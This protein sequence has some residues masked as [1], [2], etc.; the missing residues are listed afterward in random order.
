MVGLSHKEYRGRGI[1]VLDYYVSDDDMGVKDFVLGRKVDLFDSMET[2][3]KRG[4][5]DISDIIKIVS[6]EVSILSR[7]R[8]FIK[9]HNE[10][11]GIGFISLTAIRKTIGAKFNR[12]DV[13]E[14]IIATAVAAKF[15]NPT[16]Q[17]ELADVYTIVDKLT[18]TNTLELSNDVGNLIKL[19]VKLKKNS[20]AAFTNISIRKKLTLEYNAAIKYANSKAVTTY[21]KLIRDS[22]KIDTAIISSDGVS[23]EKGTKVDMSVW[24]GHGTQRDLR[25]LSHLSLSLKSGNTVTMSQ[26]G[27][28]PKKVVEFWNFFD[29]PVDVHQHEKSI[30]WFTNMFSEITG[31]IESRLGN[32]INEKNFIGALAKGIKL[33][34][35]N[36]DDS[37][38]V[39]HINKGNFNR[40]SFK[41]LEDKLHTI[42]IGVVLKTDNKLPRMAIIDK[43]SDK[44]LLGFRLE[45]RD[46]GVTY[47]LH[48]E[49]G[50]LL[51][52][53]TKMK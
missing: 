16:K 24:V 29:L 40:Y 38:I 47:K 27:A 17:I 26:K 21:A 41:N 51:N 22:H 37:V 50:P 33:N 25:K 39:L 30:P 46:G 35:T 45:I 53:L 20:F 31:K 8:S 3:G 44:R 49:K 52:E 9:I 42:N 2:F 14:G 34:A 7:N 43:N 1:S 13:S 19:E 28:T 23:N 32:D 6:K 10:R 4:S 11:L 12:G 48:V 15:I 5:L 36:N 18:T